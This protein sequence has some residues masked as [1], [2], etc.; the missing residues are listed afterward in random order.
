M[1]TKEIQVFLI[2]IL[3]GSFLLRLPALFRVPV[4][5]DEIIFSTLIEKTTFKFKDY[6][7]Q[8]TSILA[9]LPQSTY[10]Y[11][12]FHHPPFYVYTQAF[13]KKILGV[14]NLMVLPVFSGLLTI[15]LVFK[16][17]SILLDSKKGLLAAFILS[18]CPITLFVSTKAWMDS[19]LTLLLTLSV[20]FALKAKKSVYFAFM[21][22]LFLTLSLLT[23]YTAI[24]IIPTIFLIFWQ[25]EYNIKNK[26]KFFI[27]FLIPLVVSL[28]WFLYYLQTV[29]RPW[30]SLNLSGEA[31][32]MFPFVKMVN[33]RPFYFYLTQTLILFPI[34]LLPLIN[35][36]KRKNF[37]KNNLFSFSWVFSFF[38][39]LTLYGVSGR[40]M[41]MR[42]IAPLFPSLALLTAVSIRKFNNVNIFTLIIVGVYAVLTGILNSYVFVL[43][44]LVPVLDYFF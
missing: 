38:L 17:G 39:I 11:P 44:D 1:K 12:V 31:E 20:F 36:F 7:L 5:N 35:L 2:L 9:K 30:Q 22:G 34:Y 37:I 19:F 40:S 14:N 41:V 10:N 3:L 16:I 33:S 25:N 15:F 27:L 26:I 32:S 21:A 8:E 13:I 43:A 42:F 29:G 18:I 4:E 23:K 6:S 28:P 24:A